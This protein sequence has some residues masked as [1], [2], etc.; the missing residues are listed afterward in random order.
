MPPVPRILRG[1]DGGV[2]L[3]YVYGVGLTLLLFVLVT[4]LVVHQYGHGALRAVADEAARGGARTLGSQDA[5]VAACESVAEERRLGLLSERLGRDPDITCR[6][7]GD[8]VVV[9]AEAT[10]AGWLP[11]VP[12][13]RP[14]VTASARWEA[15][16]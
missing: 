3:P 14:A 2:T 1:E 15:H 9:T 5:V 8:R 16:R 13:W 12:D 7:T 6:V 10:F 4:N 11:L